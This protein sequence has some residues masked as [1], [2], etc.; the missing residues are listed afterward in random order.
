MG[1]RALATNVER[2]VEGSGRAVDSEAS[3]VDEDF[4][5]HQEDSDGYPSLGEQ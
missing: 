4:E 3:D 5:G 2:G 1:D